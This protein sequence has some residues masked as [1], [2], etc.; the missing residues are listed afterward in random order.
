M[1]RQQ[2]LVPF[3][4]RRGAFNNAHHVIGSKDVA[5]TCPPSWVTHI[6]ISKFFVSRFLIAADFQILHLWM[7]DMLSG[8]ASR[9]F[10]FLLCKKNY[11][12]VL[13]V[14]KRI[15]ETNYL[16]LLQTLDL[17]VV[18]S[19]GRSSP[20][21]CSA[22]FDS[23]GSRIPVHCFKG[24]LS[25]FGLVCAFH[26]SVAFVQTAWPWTSFLLCLYTFSAEPRSALESWDLVF[27]PYMAVRWRSLSLSFIHQT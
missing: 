15:S 14:I 5:A 7:R 6:C 13:S 8:W 26:A 9:L 19:N 22:L 21:L 20:S 2:N 10:N 16:R 23:W 12:I 27:Y 24:Y 1:P 11:S 25:F 4:R 3:V 17:V 18:V